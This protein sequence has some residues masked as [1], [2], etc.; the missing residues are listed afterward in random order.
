LPRYEVITGYDYSD[1]KED[2]VPDKEIVEAEA[3]RIE[4]G[5]L[6]FFDS[7]PL[8]TLSEPSRA[9]SAYQWYEVRVLDETE[10]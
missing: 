4:E 6:M 9:F 3:M 10:G 7:S 2:L 1:E 8:H 5:V